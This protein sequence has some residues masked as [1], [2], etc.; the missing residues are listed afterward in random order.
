MTAIAKADLYRQFDKA[1][2]WA[3]TILLIF[4]MI[5]TS[6]AIFPL[7]ALGDGA[8]LTAATRSRLRLLLLPGLVLAPLFVLMRFRA[9]TRLLLRNMSLVVMVLWS[10]IS[11][12]WSIAPGLTGR[13]VLGLTISMVIASY[14][15]IDRDIGKLLRLLSWCFLILLVANA[16]FVVGFRDLA[17]MPD[18][19]GVRGAFLH[20]NLLGETAVVG[21]IVFY[22]AF[23]SGAVN[24]WLCLVGMLLA[25]GLL[26]I[27]GAASSIV[28]A[29]VIVA[30]QAYFL[31]DVLPVRQRA[32]LFTFGLAAAFIAGGLI[33][34]N[35]DVLLGALGR[36]ATLT[37]RTYIWGYVL[38]AIAER[39]W[40]GHGY[41]AFFEAEAIAQYINDAFQWSL[42][43]AHNGYLEMVLGLGWIGLVMLITY[44]AVMVFRLIVSWQSLPKGVTMLVAP[45]LVYYLLLNITETTFLAPSGLGWFVMMVASFHLTPN[46]S[47]IAG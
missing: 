29:A 18:G 13:R 26:V 7:L 43:T 15:A 45:L 17:V 25:L 14:L 32:V 5:V 39:P 37:G 16:V 38:T 34:A 33:F 8:E 11:F 3:I 36:D 19:R 40:L 28:V 22:A 23:R 20:K 10:A 2:H 27:A 6:G 46:L 31:T 41:A 1:M 21:Q 42:P 9:I 44:F 35:A 12:T 4:W 30:L 24:R 47:R